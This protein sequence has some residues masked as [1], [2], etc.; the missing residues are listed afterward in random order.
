VIFRNHIGDLLS[1]FPDECNHNDVHSGRI[2]DLLFCFSC[3][4]SHNV[5]LG[6]RCSSDAL[7]CVAGEHH[8][9]VSI[10]HSS[11]DGDSDNGFYVVPI[12]D[13]F[14]TD[15]PP[16]RN[17]STSLIVRKEDANMCS[18]MQSLDS[19]GSFMQ[20]TFCTHFEQYLL[21]AMINR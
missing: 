12:P 4:Q 19:A 3:E 9:V 10:D 2:S 8:E 21:V 17:S 18:R 15:L 16:S 5:S 1:C 6:D 7:L 13:C 20:L 11:D 14:N